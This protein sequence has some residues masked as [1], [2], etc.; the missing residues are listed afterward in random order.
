MTFSAPFDGTPFGS[1]A[2]AGPSINATYTSQAVIEQRIFTKTIETAVIEQQIV[3]PYYSS[4]AGIE[5]RIFSAVQ[6][7]AVIEQQIYG[8]LSGI[9]SPVVTIDGTDISA[10][11]TGVIDIT[12]E[13]TASAIA[14]FTIRPAIGALD[15]LAWIGANVTIDYKDGAWATRKFTGVVS[16]PVFVPA[17]GLVTFECTG[18]L[19]GKLETKTRTEIDSIIDSEWSKDVFDDNADGWQYAQ[20]KAKTVPA[21]LWTDKNGAIRFS[22]WE[23]KATEDYL[24]TAADIK[25][26]SVSI[27]HASRRN[28]VNRVRVS[29]DYRFY[30][31]RQRTLHF[32]LVHDRPFC[33]WLNQGYT[34]PARETIRSAAES[35]SWVLTSI[36]FTPLPP[37]GAIYCDGEPRGWSYTANAAARCL[38]ANFSMA[39]RWGQQVTENYILDIQGDDSIEASGEMGV[40]ESYG[41]RSEF[42]YNEWERGQEYDGVAIGAGLHP[43][44]SGDYNIEADTDRRTE[45]EQAQRTILAKA[46]T[47]ILETH[48]ETQ[49]SFDI[50]MRP[51]LDLSHTVKLQTSNVTAKGTIER[52]RERLSIKDGSAVSTITLG[53]SRHG[54]TGIGS[55][56]PLDPADRPDALTETPFSPN[57]PLGFR[58][59]GNLTGGAGGLGGYEGPSDEHNGWSTNRADQTYDPN[60]IYYDEQMTVIVPEVEEAAINSVALQTPQLF[61]VQIP[62][63]LL[64]LTQ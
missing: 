22:D 17:T 32:S 63:D 29:L 41:I 45:M 58:I 49:V 18:D 43:G 21:S 25:P 38:G 13:K 53:I 50:L 27:K 30:N 2:D 33:D 54:G 15:L 40:R 31:K 34:L 5:Q 14:A 60:L 19:Q 62:E 16:S 12:I 23:A 59:G 36:S 37:T 39:R 48:R 57:V 24:F 64:T 26:G 10:Q 4:Q 42:D 55:G 56:T 7:T 1:E 3:W 51:D 61:H 8:A 46:S 6:S 35:T 28:M 47:E 20:D 9:W 44:G 11:L 52:I